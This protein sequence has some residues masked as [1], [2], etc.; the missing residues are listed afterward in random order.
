MKI[1]PLWMTLIHS[2]TSFA[3]L[4]IERHSYKIKLL[5]QTNQ[6]KKDHTCVNEKSA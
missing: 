1:A 3:S 2:F 6:L 4:I 5:F